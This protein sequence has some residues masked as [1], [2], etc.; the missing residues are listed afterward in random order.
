M[1]IDYFYIIN[2][3]SWGGIQVVFIVLKKCFLLSTVD[4]LVVFKELNWFNW[5]SFTVVLKLD[6]YWNFKITDDRCN[7]YLNFWP[8]KVIVH[9]RKTIIVT[10]S[11]YQSSEIEVGLVKLLLMQRLPDLCFSSNYNSHIYWFGVMIVI[12]INKIVF[13]SHLN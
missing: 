1:R 7:N 4:F 2:L 10:Y 12:R 8:V 9:I 13:L 5:F 3:D 6:C 11:T